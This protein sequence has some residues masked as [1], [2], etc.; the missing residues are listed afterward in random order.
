MINPVLPSRH[1]SGQMLKTPGTNRKARRADDD[2]A[3][4][5]QGEQTKVNVTN[6]E[7]YEQDHI[8]THQCNG[9]WPS[10]IPSYFQRKH[11]NKNKKAEA[12]HARHDAEPQECREIWLQARHLRCSR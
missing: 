8:D 3:C 5:P 11:S 6:H 7:R 12:Y 1:C 10:Q 9:P 2:K 4:P